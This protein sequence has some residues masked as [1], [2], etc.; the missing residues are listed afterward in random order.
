MK[1]NWFNTFFLMAILISCIDEE[2]I[3]RDY[4]TI[5]TN[6]V[7]EILSSGA[8]L[9]GKIESSSLSEISEYGFVWGQDDKLLPENSFSLKFGSPVT[10]VISAKIK[11]SLVAQRV[12]F[13]RFYIKT[14]DKTIYGNLVTFKSLGSEGP[15]ITG[16]N[17]D[18]GVLGDTVVIRGRNFVVQEEKNEVKFGS[19]QVPVISLSDSTITVVVPEDLSLD[20]EK[21]NVSVSIE[22]NVANSP[23][24]FTLLLEKI[25]PVITSVYPHEIKA[26]DTVLIVGKNFKANSDVVEL[27]LP[28]NTEM[29][30]I[31][32]KDDSIMFSIKLLPYG[33]F[34]FT[35][36]T[37]RFE[38]TSP[39][40]FVELRPEFISVSPEA[41]D[42]GGI[43]TIKVKNFPTCLPIVA[44]AGGY[45]AEIVSITEDEVKIKIAE[46]C[47]YGN[48]PIGFGASYYEYFLLTSPLS[49]KPAQIFSVEPN[50]GVANQEV[51]IHGDN[52]F[53]I[54]PYYTEFLNITSSS[55][56]EIR[57][58][59]KEVNAPNGVDVVVNACDQFVTLQS[60]FQYDP[61]EILDINPK[62]I[63]SPTQI[64]TIEGRNFSTGVDRNVV[65]PTNRPGTGDYL[66]SSDVSHISFSASMLIPDPLIETKFST[67]IT[68]RTTTGI[69]VTSSFELTID[70]DAPWSKLSDFPAEPRD[71]GISFS[72][73]G[74][75]YVGL[76]RGQINNYAF[77]ND[78][79]EFDPITESWTAKAGFPG[80]HGYEVAAAAT[81][82]DNAYLIAQG[83]QLWEY[84]PSQDS[85]KRK[86]DYPGGVAGDRFIIS[87]DDRIYVGGGYLGSTSFE[88]WEYS[89]ASNAWL[90]RANTPGYLN[91]YSIQFGF[92]GKGY[93]YSNIDAYK[94]F[95]FIYDPA[96]D[97]WSITPTAN[98]P[99]L[100]RWQ[101]LK[102]DDYVI[103]CGGV[104]YNS[105]N[106]IYKI[107]PETNTWS[108]VFFPG[109]RRVSHVGF[110]IGNTGYMGLGV[111]DA[112]WWTDFWKFDPEK[113]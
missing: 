43:M 29:N 8:T 54:Q 78:L 17:P 111:I 20:S 52:F 22:G 34:G 92:K 55:R 98:F 15:V 91:A 77:L 6:P 48:Y 101:I 73:N 80:V 28:Y 108:T 53:N 112:R 3:D 47:Y 9:S 37:G 21:V 83:N 74:K 81:T 2:K 89:P 61:A 93:F 26:C 30:L 27:F 99:D 79:W 66:Y 5:L 49:S 39:I 84:D 105:S 67:P 50:H 19:E 31:K 82:N 85:W 69:E 76:G 14:S 51:V 113:F 7:T 65:Y 1:Q 25:I 58:T 40:D 23:E 90:R 59:V 102:F 64:I 104:T 36:K 12:Y 109:P 96:V 10:N 33:E 18:S 32:V 68:I 60:G 110:S 24:P 41:Y 70:Y 16:L 63:T 35:I 62:V 46:S 42:P 100:G 97:A 75:G 103:V 57:G 45:G 13:V 72:I 56:T 38:L 11:S 106:T 94:K 88:F 86:A 95:K 87:I 107:I 44:S 4:P 71:Q